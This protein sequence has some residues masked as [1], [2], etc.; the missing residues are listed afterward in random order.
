MKKVLGVVVGLVLVFWIGLILF[1]GPAIK[2][3]IELVGPQVTGVPISVEKVRINPWAGSVHVKALVVG[4]P[5]GFKTAS[6]ME[7]GAF[8]LKM[9][10]PSL[11]SDTVIVRQILI[12]APQIT[13]EKS[14]TSSNLAEFEK[15]LTGG[16][17]SAA[18]EEATSDSSEPAGSGKKVIVE[19]F[20]FNG[21]RVHVSVTALGGKKLTLPLPSIHLQ[22]LGKDSGGASIGEVVSELFGSVRSAVVNV[23][24][25]GTDLAGGA[26]KGAGELAGE[27]ATGVRDAAQGVGDAASETVQEAAGALKKSLGGLFG[28]EKE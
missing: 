22:D 23:V 7:L 24:A 3:G 2:T 13:Y 11:W 6:L 17:S 14:L 8:Q 4:N 25:S 21:A 12:D 28:K 9:S 15:N 16:T 10:L 27:A 19:D 5:E 20:Q 18:S 26:L 1:L